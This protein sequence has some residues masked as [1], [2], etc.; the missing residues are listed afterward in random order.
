MQI[1]AN[2]IIVSFL[3]IPKRPSRTFRLSL[4]GYHVRGSHLILIVLELQ[5]NQHQVV[6][7]QIIKVVAAQAVAVVD[8]N[9]YGRR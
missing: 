1:D 8:I 3:C 6:V 4:V 2:L 9:Q 7:L 5:H